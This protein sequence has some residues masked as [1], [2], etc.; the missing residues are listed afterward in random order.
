MWSLPMPMEKAVVAEE[1]PE[2][3]W[4]KSD[5]AIKPVPTLTFQSC[6]DSWAAD[7]AF[8]EYRWPHLGNQALALTVCWLF[9]RK[10]GQDVLCSTPTLKSLPAESCGTRLLIS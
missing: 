2:L 4:Q 5:N 3:K 8:D 1:E 10:Q 9:E 6:L 7:T